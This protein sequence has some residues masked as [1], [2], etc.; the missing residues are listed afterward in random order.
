MDRLRITAHIQGGVAFQRDEGITLDG[1]LAYWAA[2]DRSGDAFFDRQPGHAE[3][4]EISARPDPDIGLAVH[5]AGGAWCYR[6]SLAEIAGDHGTERIHWSK[7]IDD[8]ELGFLADEGAVRV[9]GKVNLMS[10]EFKSYRQPLFLEVVGRLVWYVEGDPDRLRELV[11]RI[12]GLGKKRQSGHGRVLRWEI[13]PHDEPDRWL[14]RPD[15]SPARAIPLPMLGGWEGETAWMGYRPPY[16]L[17]ANQAL[18]AVPVAP[19]MAT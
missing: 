18:C 15:G 13:E 19:V 2:M 7:R 9:R 1:P 4:T 14:W 16:W 8:R 5:E 3:L 6:A 12:V 10:G 17:P 11:P